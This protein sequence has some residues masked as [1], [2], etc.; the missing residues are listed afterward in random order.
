MS[1]APPSSAATDG[2]ATAAACASTPDRRWEAGARRARQLAWFSLVWMAAEGAL[3]L[4][5]GERSGSS[6]LVA[7]AL[8]SA[9]EA[10][11][12][13][14]VVWRFTGSRLRSETAERGAQ[15]AVAVTFWLLAPYV[16]ILAAQQLVSEAAP[17]A[18]ALGVAVTA[19][20]VV[21]MPVLGLAKHRLG[22]RLGSAAT[23]GEGSQNYLCAAQGAAVLVALVVVASAP[24]AWWLDPAVAILLAAWA[25]REGLEA[26]R[27]ED[28]C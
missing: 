4:L 15:R 14:I 18:T 5:A 12:S 7:W 17:S 23:A 6:S 9:I 22:A 21:A 19:A 2:T 24:V 8:G 20:S 27:G 13:I 16:A 10:L 1:G 11:A 28:C 25:V 26:W 3:G